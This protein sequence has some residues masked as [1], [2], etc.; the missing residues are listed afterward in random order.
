MYHYSGLMTT[1][2]PEPKKSHITGTY[3]ISVPK[4]GITALAVVETGDW[5]GNRPPPDPND[6]FC[7][8]PFEVASK[9]KARKAAR[10][11][12]GGSN[13]SASGKKSGAGAR[14]KKAK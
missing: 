7:N 10:G 4:S 12:N 9:G 2:E 11:K 5:T 8:G 14:S 3:T 13:S 1:E 6:P